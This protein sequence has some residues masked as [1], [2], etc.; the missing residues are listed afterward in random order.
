MSTIGLGSKHVLPKKN[1]SSTKRSQMPSK[2]AEALSHLSRT[3]SLNFGYADV[4]GHIG[5]VMTGEVPKRGAP[6]AEQCLGG[7]LLAWAGHA[8]VER[9]LP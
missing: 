7:A 4:D 6:G 9:L 8:S 3:F 2:K 5:Y 1:N